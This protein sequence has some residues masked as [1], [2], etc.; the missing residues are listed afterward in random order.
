MTQDEYNQRL[1]EGEKKGWVYLIEA[2]P[3]G[4]IKIG[5]AK[6]PVKRLET[7][8]TGHHEELV[9]FAVLP[10]T[11]YLEADL[12]RRLWK[13]RTRGEWFARSPVLKLLRPVIAAQGLNLA[14]GSSES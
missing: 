14:S 7:L 13:F 4:P 3:R 6:D 2:D 9:L 8:Q 12:H 11:R 1:A 10:G 5:W